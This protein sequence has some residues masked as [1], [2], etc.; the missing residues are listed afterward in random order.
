M[1]YQPYVYYFGLDRPLYGWAF[2]AYLGV[3]RIMSR[4]ALPNECCLLVLPPR[5]WTVDEPVPSGNQALSASR[6]TT[7][8]SP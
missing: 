8:M 5:P 7:T 6:V 3:T 4:G 1:N 2:S